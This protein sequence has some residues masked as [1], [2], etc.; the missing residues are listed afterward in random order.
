MND[1]RKIT[2]AFTGRRTYS[3]EGDEELRELLHYLYERG[4]RRFLCGM[5]WGFDL[6]AGRQ[7]EMLKAE[8]E[9]VVLIAVEPFAEFG[10]MFSGEDALLYERLLRVADERVVVGERCEAAYM[11]RNDFLVDNASLVVAWWDNLPR[12]GTAYTVRRARH[13]RVEVANLYPDAQLE[14][15]F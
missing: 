4:Y 15:E 9:D 6:A 7:V 3:G 14:L 12:G 10:S 5:A 1:P 8:K 11:R 13:Q 2:A